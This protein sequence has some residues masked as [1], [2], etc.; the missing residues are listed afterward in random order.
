MIDSSD[1]RKINLNLIRL[2]MWKGGEYTKQ[3]VAG[4]VGLSIATC[5]TLLNE[6]EKSGE[7]LSERRQLK[8][9][10]RSS[11]IY[12]INEA[13]ES[14]LCI[15]FDLHSDGSRI[16]QSDVLSM[17]GNS[18]Y[19]N[20]E[21]FDYLE[22]EQITKTIAELLVRFPNISFVAV[23]T[24]G[25]VDNGV[26]R[27]ADIPEMENV[28]LE[29]MIRKEICGIPLDM[30]YN[31]QYIAYGAYKLAGYEKKETLSLIFSL[32]NVLPGGA[33]VVNGIPVSGKNGFAGMTGYLPYNV[34]REEQIRAV[35]EEP[36]G[37]MFLS[38]AAASIIAVLNPDELVF[39]GNTVDSDNVERVRI[40]CQAYFPDGILPKFTVV[41]GLAG[42]YYLRGMY[43]R[44]LEIKA[45]TIMR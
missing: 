43:E 7:L 42:D 5:N 10:G 4:E 21:W 29:E 45:G 22:A 12:R 24:N 6:L 16:L 26:I 36:E 1:V 8:V 3:A 35:A 37:L 27:V 23:G 30:A 41:E 39:A 18:I 40:A 9:V 32:K 28:P 38:R 20:E 17:L 33:S 44:V 19:K 31:C 2:L 14:I 13:F 15:R 25:I 34:E 11:S